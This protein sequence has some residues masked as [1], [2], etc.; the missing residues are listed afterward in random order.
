MVVNEKHYDFLREIDKVDRRVLN[1]HLNEMVSDGIL[2]KKIFNELPPRVEYQ[3]TQLG[4]E[5]VDLLWKL[6]EWGKKLK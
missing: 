3:L 5:L 4:L 2:S 6:D 1:Q